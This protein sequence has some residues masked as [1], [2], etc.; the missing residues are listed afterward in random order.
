MTDNPT[1]LDRAVEL[2]GSA[3]ALGRLL[4][5][6]RRPNGLTRAAV[7]LWTR[8]GALVPA[9]H[10]PNIERVTLGKVRCEELRPDVDWAYLR[11]SKKTR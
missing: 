5:S 9:E 4:K 7:L 2:A 1:P 8:P 10:C 3:A 11:G 6:Q